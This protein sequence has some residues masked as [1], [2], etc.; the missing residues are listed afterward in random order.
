MSISLN[1]VLTIVPGNAEE[2]AAAFKECAE[3][4]RKEKGCIRYVMVK[5]IKTS[6]GFQVCC[7]CVCAPFSDRY[8]FVGRSNIFCSQAPMRED[9]YIILEEW[10]SMDDLNVHVQQ[11]PL[12]D[13]LA[14]TQGMVTLTGNIMTNV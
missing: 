11:K 9:A 13:F 12:A 5:D 7:S 14:K 3:Q 10:A 4:V 6:L 8:F 2:V 1:V